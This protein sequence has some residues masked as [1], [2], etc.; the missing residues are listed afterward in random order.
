M[1]VNQAQDCID[2][3]EYSEWIAFNNIDPFTIDRSEQMLAVVCS[4]LA[5]THRK[6][7]KPYGP[8]DFLPKYRQKPV[9]SQD[10][11]SKLKV[12]FNGN[13]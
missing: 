9:N 7:N 11:E 12:L 6:R 8:D 2:S 13:N 1:S 5:N 10:I 4:I 3:A